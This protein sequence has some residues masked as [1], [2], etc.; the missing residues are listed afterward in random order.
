MCRSVWNSICSILTLFD[1]ISVSI[2]ILYFS[3]VIKF[4]LFSTET[5]NLFTAKNQVSWQNQIKT[6]CFYSTLVCNELV[7]RFLFAAK[8]RKQARS[9]DIQKGETVIVFHCAR[10]KCN[11]V[12]WTSV[13]WLSIDSLYKNM[14][15]KDVISLMC[16]NAIF[17]IPL[18]VHNIE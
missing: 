9:I 18:V 10:Y 15:S 11:F 16:Y 1:L 17:A 12:L 5:E 2:C 6:C 3:L 13:T 8:Y 7:F 4:R 14:R